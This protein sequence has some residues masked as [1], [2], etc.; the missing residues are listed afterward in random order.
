MS[1]NENHNYESLQEET[2]TKQ[3]IMSVLKRK[4][5]I[6]LNAKPNK[7]IRQKLHNCQK[8]GNLNHSEMHLF[9]KVCM[10]LGENYFL[11]F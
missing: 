2:V 4:A 6:D 1:I 5:A 11:R 3:K 7:L 10:K 9:R 8:S